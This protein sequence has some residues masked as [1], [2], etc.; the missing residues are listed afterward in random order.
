M[1]IKLKVHNFYTI[2]VIEAE[3]QVVLNTNRTRIPGCISKMAEALRT[4]DTRRRG[5]PHGCW[6][7]VGPKL[8]PDQMAA[9]VL[10]IM[11]GSLYTMHSS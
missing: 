5:L 8:V 7:L 1:K 4:V 9:P 10:E 3:S 6:W 2:E 11:N